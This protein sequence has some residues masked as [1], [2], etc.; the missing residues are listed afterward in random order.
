VN[1]VNATGS[2]DTFVAGIL[3]GFHQGWKFERCLTFGAAAGGANARV[4][5]VAVAAL[6]DI[7]VLEQSVRIQRVNP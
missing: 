3:Y 2:G 6:Q 4:W 7:L 5:D 1:T